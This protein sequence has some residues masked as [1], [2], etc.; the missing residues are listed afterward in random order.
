MHASRAGPLIKGAASAL[1]ETL[2]HKMTTEAAGFAIHHE[3]S[4]ARLVRRGSAGK[5]GLQTS[6]TTLVVIAIAIHALIQTLV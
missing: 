6:Y 4:L 5:F 3:R 1:A 2:A